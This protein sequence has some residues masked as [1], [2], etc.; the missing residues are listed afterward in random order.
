MKNLAIAA[1]VL[2]VVLVIGATG[3]LI[4][5]R[6]NTDKASSQTEYEKYLEDTAQELEN[7]QIPELNEDEITAP[8]DTKSSQNVDAAVKAIDEALGGMDKDMTGLNATTDFAD[9]GTVE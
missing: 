3:V 8:V 9:F 4:L 5:R 2:G 7:E 1:I 6:N